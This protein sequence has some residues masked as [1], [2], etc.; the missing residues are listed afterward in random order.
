MRVYLYVRVCVA[1]CKDAFSHHIPHVEREANWDLSFLQQ[2]FIYQH[3]LWYYFL[4]SFGN[5]F[6]VFIFCYVVFTAATLLPAYMYS[7]ALSHLVR[8]SFS[9][10][11][12]FYNIFPLHHWIV[13]KKYHGNCNGN[14]NSTRT[15]TSPP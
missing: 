6:P 14:R 7:L 10:P 4:S 3:K 11:L 2:N 8:Y 5:H 15:P 12:F 9:R 13:I 1:S